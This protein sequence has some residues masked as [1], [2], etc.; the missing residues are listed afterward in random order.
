M[1]CQYRQYNATTDEVY[2]VVMVKTISNITISLPKLLTIAFVVFQW[3][4]KRFDGFKNI[5]FTS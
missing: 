3:N 4:C 1:T 2:I 5:T